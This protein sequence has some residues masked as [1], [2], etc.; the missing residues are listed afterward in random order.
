MEL[1]ADDLGRTPEIRVVG[2]DRPGMNQ[3]RITVQNRARART[4][5]QPYRDTTRA[6]TVTRLYKHVSVSHVTATYLSANIAVPAVS[7]VSHGHRDLWF[8]RS[9]TSH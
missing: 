3:E 8:F 7:D 9:V 6:R 1:T 2:F 4:L 5:I